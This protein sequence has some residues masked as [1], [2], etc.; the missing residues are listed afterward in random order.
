MIYL[1]RWVQWSVAV[2][3]GVWGVG[4]VALDGGGVGAYIAKKTK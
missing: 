1:W 3:A 2:G 4:A